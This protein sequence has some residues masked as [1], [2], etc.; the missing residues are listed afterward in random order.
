MPEGV[1]LDCCAT[2]ARFPHQKQHSPDGETH[3]GEPRR[4]ANFAGELD[5]IALRKWQSG[6]AN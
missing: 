4:A 5:P 2:G 6:K 3:V 1:S